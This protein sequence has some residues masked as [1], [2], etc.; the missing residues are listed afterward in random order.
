MGSAL[1]T[2]RSV[3]AW[4]L[5]NGFRSRVG[6]SGHLYYEHPASG[7]KIVMPGHGRPTLSKRIA[8]QVLRTLGRIGFD[9]ARVRAEMRGLA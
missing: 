8:S 7:V 3:T 4:L 1:L 2:R 6:K 5:S 9:R